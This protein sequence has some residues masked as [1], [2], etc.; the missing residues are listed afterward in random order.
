MVIV[1]ILAAIATPSFLAMNNR[2]KLN[3]ALNTVKG[4]MQEAQRQAMRNSKSCT[5]T[6]DVTNNKITSNNGCLVTGD[7][8]LPQGVN[9]AFNN[10]STINYGMRGNTTTNKTI[11][12][13]LA[14]GSGETKCLAIS[15]PLGVIRT[16]IYDGTACKKA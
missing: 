10:S 14:D 7:R 16:G 1:G 15:M 6:L 5:I 9:L 12:L 8:T 11:R 3:D 4:A 2:A 13:S